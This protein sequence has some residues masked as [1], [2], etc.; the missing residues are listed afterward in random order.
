MTNAELIAKIKAEI[1]RLRKDNDISDDEC[2][3]YEYDVACGYDMALDDVLGILSVLEE[4]VRLNQEE[5]EEEKSA[6]DLIAEERK[7]Q[8]SKGFN[9]KH[10][11]E[12]DCHQLSDA[13]IVYA[14]PGPLRYQVMNWWPW[15]KKWLKEDDSFTTQGRIRE[16]VKAGA[17]IVA[18]IERLQ[19]TINNYDKKG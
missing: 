14:A 11:D 7:R 1:E 8:I 15:D 5:L 17:L 4:S 2:A 10:D 6:I 3:Q 19:R 12:H 16:L 9:W 13:A 18:E